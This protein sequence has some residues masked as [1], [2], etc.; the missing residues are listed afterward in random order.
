M[1][2][3]LFLMDINVRGCFLVPPCSWPFFENRFPWQ[4]LLFHNIPPILHR[5]RTQISAINH[6]SVLQFF[7][8]IVIVGVI[9]FFILGYCDKDRSLFII[10]IIIVIIHSM[11]IKIY[12]LSWTWCHLYFHISIS[13]PISL[14]FFSYVSI[15]SFQ[16]DTGGKYSDK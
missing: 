3:S 4:I 16:P 2:N 5:Y 1:N 15:L 6:Y 9:I 13:K 11:I 8:Y 14:I 7:I 12:V 10:I